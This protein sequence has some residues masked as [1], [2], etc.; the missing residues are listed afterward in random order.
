VCI[1]K[2]INLKRYKRICCKCGVLPF[3]TA[4]V[5]VLPAGFLSDFLVKKGG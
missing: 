4:F 3:L 2:I 5:G 1:K